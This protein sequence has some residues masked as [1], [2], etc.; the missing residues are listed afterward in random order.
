MGAVLQETVQV[1]N[2]VKVLAHEL[3]SPRLEYLG[4]AA[5]MRSFCK[6]LSEQKG[7]EIDFRREFR[8]T[9]SLCH[10]KPG[11]AFPSSTGGSVQCSHAQ[12]GETD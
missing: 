7:I 3:Y 12:R 2:D 4:I 8:S 10:R 6:D 5:V 9:L 11:F 1:L